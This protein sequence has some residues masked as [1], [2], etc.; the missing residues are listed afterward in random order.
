MAK[1][2]NV[3]KDLF[4]VGVLDPTLRVFDIIMHTPFGTTYNS[5]LLKGTKANVLFETVKETHFTQFE[6]RIETVLKE[7]EK[8][9]YVVLNHTEP[10]HSG[11]LALLMARFPDA[12]IVAT[13]QALRNI[14]FI[15]N[16]KFEKTIAVTSKTEPIDIGGYTLKFIISPFLHWPDTMITFIPELKT[17]V[18][19]DFF[20]AHYSNPLVFND[21]ISKDPAMK[22]D[23][24]SAYRNYFDCIFGPFKPYV[25]QG[26]DRLKGLD[27]DTICCSHGPVL[28]EDLPYYLDLYRNWSTPLVSDEPP[29]V[30]IAYVS[31][32]QFTKRLADTIGEALV[33]SGLRVQQ[34]D[35]VST[36]LGTVME[37]VGKARG[38]LLGTPTLV[39]EA[40]PPVW[41]IV[42][43]LNPI[44]HAGMTLGVFGSYGWSGE[45]LRNIQGRLAQ[46]SSSME[47]PL[48]PFGVVFKPDEKDLVAAREWATQF[49]AAVKTNAEKYKP[50]DVVPRRFPQ[51]ESP[52]ALKNIPF[53]G[54]HRGE[55]VPK[56]DH[57][58]KRWKC[59]ICNE[60]ILS[61]DE[62]EICP[63]CGATGPESFVIVGYVD[64]ESVDKSQIQ[65][66]L[67]S[68]SRGDAAKINGR[69]GKWRCLICGEVIESVGV[70]EVCPVCG[71]TGE[72][73]FEFIGFV[74]EIQKNASGACSEER[75]VVVGVGAAGFNAAKTVRELNAE[76]QV[77]LVNNESDVPYTRPMVTDLVVEPE[78]KKGP[79]FKLADDEWYKSNNVELLMSS[80]VVSV[81]TGKRTVSVK[82]LVGGET[83]TIQYTK[84]ILATGGQ[85]IVP[86]DK[87]P[88]TN[89]FGVRTS[90]DID[91][92]LGFVH[93]AP[94]AKE[95]MKILIVG[96]GL[97]ALELAES[98]TEIGFKHVDVIEMMPRILP[99]QLTEDASCVFKRAIESKGVKLHLGTKITAY[100]LDSAKER[101]VSVELSSGDTVHLD[102]LCW[103]IGTRQEVGLASAI[104]C[105]VER[106]VVVDKF[107]RT[108]VPNVFAC[109]DC[110]QFEGLCVC[111]WMEAVTEGRVAGHNVLAASEETMEAYV[112]KDHPYL[113][114]AFGGAFSIGDISSR[115]RRLVME[116]LPAPGNHVE[117]FFNDENAVVGAI[118]LGPEAISKLQAPLTLQVQSRGF[119][120][121]VLQRISQVFA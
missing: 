116:S 96:G 97:A 90:A 41:D 27:F 9:D 61:V 117:L 10:D 21:E 12:T 93:K 2:L 112:R 60:I 120:S 95:T 6:E 115:C 32:Y 94:S 92:I 119:V 8:I 84:L 5:F 107:M 29:L 83:K 110:A 62:P 59:L 7:G 81:D 43:R 73:S 65:C 55:P 99:R 34:F 51:S 58:M 45:G 20:G 25:L 88:H 22:A 75:I 4:W 19:C 54:A 86:A 39:G 76:C 16:K 106:G 67:P 49:V 38:L 108:S 113:L 89:V 118:A 26:L 11:S 36:E 74:D 80:E 52:A 57:R 42:S 98:F 17:I 23:M 28:R 109:G 100:N 35:M 24:L 14:Q 91:R 72:E 47:V 3:K 31:A 111:N 101:V 63:V 77:T 68:A 69:L 85:N 13:N 104:G 56:K 102:A 48:Y 114:D 79:K 87:L 37:S 71:A 33:A 53:P 40:L 105:K 30:V 78:A 18:T 103:A 15:C 66:P 50:G 121:C 1:A 44:V 64:D 70:P 46:L 82:S